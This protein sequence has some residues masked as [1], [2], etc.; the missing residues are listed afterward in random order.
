MGKIAFIAPD[1]ILLENSKKIAHEIACY[2]DTDFYFSQLNDAVI[3]AKSL[4][5]SDVDAI[6]SRYGTAYL[7]TEANLNIPIVEIM[8]TG[9]DLAQAFFEAK[10]RTKLQHP[11]ITYLA[12]NNMANDILRLSKILDIELQVISL[13]STEDII[14]TLDHLPLNSTDIMMGGANAMEY[15]AQKGFLTHLVQSGECS[16]REAFRSAKKILLAR[17]NER[18]HTEEFL[19]VINAMREGIIS[20]NTTHHIRTINE[21]AEVFLQKNAKELTGHR[22]EEFL[23]TQHP[24]FPILPLIDECLAK[25]QRILDKILK[26][27]PLWITFNFLPIIVKKKIIG[28][29]ITTQDITQIQE[30]EIKIRHEV[31][32]KKF[33]AHYQFSD[34]LGGS[35]EISESKRLANEFAKIDTTVLLFGESGTGKELFAQSIHNFSTRNNGP[36][37]AINCAALPTNLL[38]SELFGYV[39]GA[40][41]GAK[42]KGKAGLFEMAHRGTIFLDEISEMDP[43]GQSRLLRVL[44]ERQVMR[45]GDDKYIPIDVRVIAATNK[46]LPDLVSKGKFRQDLFYRLKVLTI[47]IPPLRERAGDIIF[48]ARHFLNHYVLKYNR[49]HHFTSSA[50]IMLTTYNWPGNIRELRYFIERLCIIVPKTIIDED[51]LETYWDDRDDILAPI[52]TNQVNISSDSLETTSPTDEKSHILS[53]LKTTHS[54]ISQAAHLLEM[55]RSTL[56]RKLRTHHICIQKNYK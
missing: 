17:S 12:F 11:R 34:I 15:A 51:L 13:N 37:V 36:F 10:K 4:E 8:I 44:Q 56:Y 38:E 52:T 2:E 27:G 18:K 33:I 48:L 45:L 50:E 6:I 49:P 55:D 40:F 53:V 32:T 35:T 41:T 16:L 39:D 31:L 9:Q 1:K 19:T 47:Q 5:Y 42:R 29:A 24:L 14:S 28:A 3:L 25:G 7:L 26:I 21:A 54:N 20:I 30:M 43:Y 46:H 23:T 22:L